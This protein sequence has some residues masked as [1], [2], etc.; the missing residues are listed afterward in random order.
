MVVIET[1]RKFLNWRLRPDGHWPGSCSAGLCRNR[2]GL[3]WPLLLL[4]G[5]GPSA[6]AA[7]AAADERMILDV[8]LLTVVE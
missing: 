3:R 2:V 5:R 6:F 7:T 1:A 4:V 8:W